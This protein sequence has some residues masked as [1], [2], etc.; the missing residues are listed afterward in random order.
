MAPTANQFLTFTTRHLAK[1][2]RRHTSRPSKR[3]HKV[4]EITESDLES[5]LGDRLLAIRQ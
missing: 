4:R 1:S 5:D 3:P 2:S